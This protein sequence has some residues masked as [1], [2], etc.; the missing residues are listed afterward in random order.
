MTPD[1]AA[2][3]EWDDCMSAHYHDGYEA[4]EADARSGRPYDDRSGLMPATWVE[5][6]RDG[7]VA[8]AWRTSSPMTRAAGLR[9]GHPARR[10]GFPRSG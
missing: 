7:Y 10:Q 1:E 6:Y 8:R 3:P 9:T 2:E 5:G 4:G